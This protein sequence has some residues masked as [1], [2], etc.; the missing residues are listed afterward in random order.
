M[1][2][3]LSS[4]LLLNILSV[5]KLGYT[6]PP[7]PAAPTG[8][9]DVKSQEPKKIASPFDIFNEEYWRE[10][11]REYARKESQRNWLNSWFT[12]WFTNF[13]R[14]VSSY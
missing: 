2:E 9:R 8:Y 3:I 4:F 12:Y 14:V 5:D 13:C 11:T 10:K 1:V 7:F 6:T